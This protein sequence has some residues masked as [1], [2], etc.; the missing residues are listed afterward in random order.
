MLNYTIYGLYNL[1]DSPSYENLRYIGQT[2]REP[3]ERLSEHRIHSRHDTKRRVCRWIQKIGEDNLGIMSLENGEF[4]SNDHLDQREMHHIAEASSKGLNLKNLTEGG[5]GTRGY[6]WS[7]ELINQ[8]SGEGNSFY[9]KSH[10][11]ETRKLLSEKS[12]E[13][14]N[15]PEYANKVRETFT[16]SE[17]IQKIWEGGESHPFWGKH[18]KDSTKQLLSEASK[19]HWENASSEQRETHRQAGLKS[20]H[21]RWHASRNKKSSTC[22]YCLVQE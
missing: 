22:Q 2:T 13:R 18:H 17:K 15:D 3:S 7:P 11:E 4:I 1:N 9:G 12:K 20:S 19:K 10:T 5:R 21:Q 6:T 16:S 14:W 8:R